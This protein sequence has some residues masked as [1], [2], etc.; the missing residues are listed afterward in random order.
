[1]DISIISTNHIKLIYSSTHNSLRVCE[2][3]A[4]VT[5]T[6]NTVAVNKVD[7]MTSLSPYVKSRLANSVGYRL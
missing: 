2:G 3:Y 5:Y 6:S 7:R 1:M 4:A